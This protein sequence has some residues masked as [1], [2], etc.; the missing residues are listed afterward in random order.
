MKQTQTLMTTA[1]IL[2]GS[3]TATWTAPQSPTAAFGHVAHGRI[4]AR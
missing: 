1:L 4:D 2:A 3:S